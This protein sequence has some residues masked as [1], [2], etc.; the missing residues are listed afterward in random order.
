VVC[1]GLVAVIIDHKV[2]VARWALFG[3]RAAGNAGKETVYTK[4]Q[5]LPQTSK[6]YKQNSLHSSVLGIVDRLR[7]FHP[8]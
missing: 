7:I 8:P 5:N 6:Y 1:L 4:H 3:N 2:G